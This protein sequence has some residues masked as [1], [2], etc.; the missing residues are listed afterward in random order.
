MLILIKN[1]LYEITLKFM[2]NYAWEVL[3][4]GD[5]SKI[6]IPNLVCVYLLFIIAILFNDIGTF[7]NYIIKKNIYMNVFI[8]IFGMLLIF[9]FTRKRVV[10]EKIKIYK[11]DFFPIFI[12]VIVALMKLPLPDKSFDTVYYHVFQ[13]NS[14]FVDNIRSNYFPI[15]MPSFMF[16]LADRMFYPFRSLFGY[17]LGTILNTLVLILIYFQ[18]KDIILRYISDKGY[19]LKKYTISLL[20][21][22]IISTEYILINSATYMVDLFYLPLCLEFLRILFFYEDYTDYLSYYVSLLFGISIT[23]KL[24]NMI[25]VLILLVLYIVKFRKKITISTFVT[26]V[27]V[28]IVPCAI[29]LVYNY[30]NTHNPVFPFYNNIFGS[31]FYSHSNFK[32]TRWD[33]KTVVEYIS[34]PIYVF[35]N[36]KRFSELSV[37]SGRIAIGTIA[38]IFLIILF[39]KIDNSYKKNIYKYSIIIL[40]A[41]IFFWEITTGYVRYMLFVEILSGIL[42]TFIILDNLQGSDKRIGIISGFFLMILILQSI[43]CYYYVGLKNTDWAWRSSIR[44]YKTYLGNISL[45]GKDKSADG[46]SNDLNDVEVWA[47]INHN[48]AY[49]KMLKNN[50]PMFDLS[51]LSDI[52]TKDGVNFLEANKSKNIYTLVGEGEFDESIKIINRYDYRIVK[53]VKVVPKFLLKDEAL[54]AI[55]IRKDDSAKNKLFLLNNDNKTLMLESSS[56]M[57]GTK[58]SLFYGYFPLATHWGSDGCILNIDASD[59]VKTKNIF[60]EYMKPGEGFRSIEVDLDKGSVSKVGEQIKIYYSNEAGKNDV[61]DW[62]YI[63]NPK[64]E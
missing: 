23:L 51:Y 59:G 54:Y 9:F 5:N 36:P 27:F 31:Q 46:F 2:I 57:K 64:I 22:L 37:Y 11:E 35:F 56:L 4:I 19:N 18:V 26:C 7:V 17:R 43:L 39:N 34:W 20:S 42:V 30:T 53:V 25:F 24:T 6:L 60:K 62:I 14:G 45:I 61:G 32:D 52:K 10:I 12:I 8:V 40:I 50:I 3:M 48:G 44:N 16:P 41:S 21:L 33:P 55:Q 47:I 58:L 1:S 15:G 49:A 38:G 29:Y 13:Q 28:A 63:I